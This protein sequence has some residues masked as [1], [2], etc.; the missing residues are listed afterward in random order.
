[1]GHILVWVTLKDGSGC[2]SGEVYCGPVCQAGGTET[3]RQLSGYYGL[4]PT[5]P[6]LHMDPNS[7]MPLQV[8]NPLQVTREREKR[9]LQDS[10]RANSPNNRFVILLVLAS[11]VYQG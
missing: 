10:N 4:A 6:L 5:S 2:E 9:K 8:S 1:M 3:D 7:F 11:G